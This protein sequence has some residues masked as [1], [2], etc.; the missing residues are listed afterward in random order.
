MWSLC[1]PHVAAPFVTHDELKAVDRIKTI[2][3]DNVTQTLLRLADN[4]DLVILRSMR[5][6]TAG[7]LMVSD[8]TT[9]L[10]RELTCSIVLFG[11]PH[12]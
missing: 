6:R 5:R 11:E 1:L 8:V 9:Q 7:G 10:I 12:M 4:F 3:H 2:A